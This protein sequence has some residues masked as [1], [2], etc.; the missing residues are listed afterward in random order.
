M[1]P[2]RENAATL[3]KGYR[4]TFNKAYNA[5]PDPRDLENLTAEDFT[6][7]VPSTNSSEDHNWLGQLPAMRRWKGSRVIN[8][9]MVGRITVTNDSFEAT[10][11]VPVTA[12]EDDS[13]GLFSPLFSAMG[14]EGRDLW[15]GLGVKALLGN[16]AWADGNP[17]FCSA[18]PLADGAAPL[19]NGVTT[20]FSAPAL[21]AADA[22]LR[23]AQLGPDQSANVL[24]RLLIVGPSKA[25]EARRILRGEIVAA[26]SGTVSESNPNKGLVE[27]RVCNDLVGSHANKWFLLGEVAGIRSVCVQVRKEAMLVA[28]N[29]PTDDNVFLNNE[30]LFGTDARGEAFLTLPFLAYAGGLASVAA[31]D[32]TKVPVEA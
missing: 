15:R 12:I 18:R 32:E 14:K 3:F 9:L 2:T 8:Q 28:K 31:Y 24:P 4:A 22:A 27:Y 20:A 26:A 5:D 16:A 23:S 6:M 1:I 13:Y 25:S 17:F 7:S 19:T 21:E 10:V 30:A 29:Q 11:S